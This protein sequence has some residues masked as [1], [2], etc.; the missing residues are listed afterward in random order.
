MQIVH[1]FAPSKGNIILG[2]RYQ[3]VQ[4][5]GFGDGEKEAIGLGMQTCMKRENKLEANRQ[6]QEESNL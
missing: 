3:M 4:R 5:E 1:W 6:I 2:T